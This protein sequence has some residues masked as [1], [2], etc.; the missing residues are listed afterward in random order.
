MVLS[1]CILTT[2]LI[3]V[4][5]LLFVSSANTVS[6]VEARSPEESIEHA[7]P[8]DTKEEKVRPETYEMQALLIVTGFTL[9][10]L[11]LV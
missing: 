8:M 1:R 2:L 3:G 6:S 9:A 4:V 7:S 11:G 5:T 10:F